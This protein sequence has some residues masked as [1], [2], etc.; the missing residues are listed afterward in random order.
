MDTTDPHA[1]AAQALR[2]TLQRCVRSLIAELERKGR[3]SMR[4]AALKVEGREQIAV[5]AEL[6]ERAR[7]A[8]L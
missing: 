8:G 5:A 6:R 2:V 7:K 3:A 1:A 4:V